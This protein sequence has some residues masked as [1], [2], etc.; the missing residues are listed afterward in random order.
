VRSFAQSLLK[1]KMQRKFETPR[2]V[3]AGLEK[4]P[5]HSVARMG[6][7]SGPDA[8]IAE[9]TLSRNGLGVQQLLLKVESSRPRLVLQSRGNNAWEPYIKEPLRDGRTKVV[10]IPDFSDA[11]E[12]TFVG[13]NSSE[14]PHIGGTEVALDLKKH[15]LDDITGTI[16]LIRDPT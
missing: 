15:I 16:G 4:L 1:M 14:T 13:S 7:D 10:V 9:A 8:S 11:I 5:T 2:Q 3:G 6:P 12:Q